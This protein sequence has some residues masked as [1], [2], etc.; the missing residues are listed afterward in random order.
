MGGSD[1]WER[2]LRTERRR[3]EAGA[4][5]ERGL[6]DLSVPPSP[7]PC[8]EASPA[9]PPIQAGQGGNLDGLKEAPGGL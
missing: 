3:N 6:Q 1:G 5:R 9:R 8:G 2:E 4:G 7:A